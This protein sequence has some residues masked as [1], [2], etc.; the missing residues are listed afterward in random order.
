MTSN[1]KRKLEEKLIEIET[2]KIKYIKKLKSLKIREEKNYEE[3]T[4]DEHVILICD[5]SSWM[6]STSYYE[7]TGKVPKIMLQH[8]ITATYFFFFGK[9]ENTKNNGFDKVTLNIKDK[10][11][12]ENHDVLKSIELKNKIYTIREKSTKIDKKDSKKYDG[13]LTI[14]RIDD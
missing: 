7:Y 1:K 12:L 9:E 6:H 5:N 2:K 14:N 8:E 4:E 11:N 13:Y 10:N 3:Y